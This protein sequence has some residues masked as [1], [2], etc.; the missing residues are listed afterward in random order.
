MRVV[1]LVAAG[2]VNLAICGSSS[3]C[4]IQEAAYQSAYTKAISIAN[5]QLSIANI[6]RDI[7]TPVAIDAARSHYELMLMASGETRASAR[8]I[9]AAFENSSLDELIRIATMAPRYSIFYDKK[10]VDESRALCEHDLSYARREL[11]IEIAKM[12]VTSCRG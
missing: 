9:L 3:A 7:Y 5:L 12:Q 8:L 1:S 11:D 6:C 2:L 10:R 4:L